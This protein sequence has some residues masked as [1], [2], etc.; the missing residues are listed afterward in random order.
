MRILFT[1]FPLE[2]AYG[3]AEIQ[4]IG[5]MEA[6]LARGHAVAF[7]GSC[8]VLLK[9]CGERGI[10]A[11]ELRIGAPPVTKW[12]ALSFMWRK[13]RMQAALQSA[14]ASFHDIDAVCMLSLSEKLLLT[15]HAA[16][17]AKIFWIEHDKIGRW[18]LKNPWLNKLRSASKSATVVAVSEFSKTLFTR[19]VGL[20]PKRIVAIHNGI[21]PKHL[22]SSTILEKPM[23]SA[24]HIGTVARLSQDKGVDVLL[25]AVRTLP[26]VTLTVVGDGRDASALHRLGAEIDAG[27]GRIRFL[28]QVPE[29]I[30]AFYRSLD[31]FVLPSSEHDPCPL[32]PAEAMTLGIATILTD[33]CGTAGYVTNNRDALVV[34]AGNM[35]ALRDAIRRLSDPVIRHAIADAG[36]K[37]AETS[38][39]FER[40]TDRYE[41]LLMGRT[42]KHA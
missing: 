9:L 36:C 12:S 30:G 22:E 39:S 25:E 32:A 11:A 15:E 17:N 37:T 23:K 33:A 41:S 20:D 38:F 5:L 29:G 35:P 18:L 27:T 13:C 26:E 6:L 10:P 21:N 34:P 16:A 3:G 42:L 28:S 14:F 1:R 40:M 19:D 2:S 31:L 4:T 7:L 24:L 8:P